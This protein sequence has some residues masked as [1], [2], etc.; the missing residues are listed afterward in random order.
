MISQFPPV[1]PRVCGEQPLASSARTA[2]TGSS[3]RVRGT[4]NSQSA[5]IIPYRFIPACAGNSQHGQLHLH[6]APVHPR[7]CGE[8]YFSVEWRLFD[9]GSSPR[10][11]GTGPETVEGG[12]QIRFIPAC[13]GNSTYSP[14]PVARQSVHPRV[15]GEQVTNPAN[16]AGGDGSSPRVR[17]TAIA[18]NYVVKRLQVHPRVCG[19]QE[20]VKQQSTK[21]VGSSPRVRGTG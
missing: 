19:E 6:P 12:D 21:I 5:G 8:Q 15:C 11:R 3:P 18:G 1:H 4:E 7:V 17:G 16:P 9:Y 2:S 14:L 20:S 13:A 10:V